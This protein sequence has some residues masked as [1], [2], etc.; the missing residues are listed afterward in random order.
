MNT[1]AW[2]SFEVK[3]PVRTDVKTLY[4]CWTT[5]SGIESWFLRSAIFTSAQGVT[6][7][8]DEPIQKG[9]GYTWHWH[10]YNDDAVEKRVITEANGKDFLQFE[11]SGNCLVTVRLQ[12]AKDHTMVLLTQ[13]RIPEDNNP[14]TNLF[15][16][17]QLGWSFYLAN[18]KSIVEGGIDL[19]NRDTTLTHVVNA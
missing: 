18:L 6:R 9:D 8:K 15:V 11:F 7:K 17:C 1:A 19:R 16:G 3:I 2:N 4:E 12:P 5:Q 13:E 10:G 14:K